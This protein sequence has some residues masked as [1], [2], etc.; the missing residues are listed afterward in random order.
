M[1]NG[2]AGVREMLTSAID[3]EGDVEM[4]LMW[5]RGVVNELIAA[6]IENREATQEFANDGQPANWVRWQNS[7]SR[8]V[9]ALA[10]ATGAK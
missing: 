7:Q 3:G 5:V 4:S 9:A 10:A 2:H 6:V 1:G 8:L